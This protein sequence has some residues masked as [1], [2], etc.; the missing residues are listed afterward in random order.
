MGAYGAWMV[1][2][3]V[4]MGDEGDTENNGVDEAEANWIDGYGWFRGRVLG[5]VGGIADASGI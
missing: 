1:G 2:V 5:L 4:I 3:E